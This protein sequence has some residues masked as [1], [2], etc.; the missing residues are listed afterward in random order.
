MSDVKKGRKL[1]LSKEME[2]HSSKMNSNN[3]YMK[4]YSNFYN[5]PKI[6]TAKHKTPSNFKRIKYSSF[7]SSLMDKR[8][9][10]SKKIFSSID[11]EKN[12]KDRLYLEVI[13]TKN[14]VKIINKELSELKSDYN[15]LEQGN[16]TNMHIIENLL[17]EDELKEEENNNNNDEE[18]NRINVLKKH[19]NFYSLRVY[20]NQIKLDGLKNKEKQKKYQELKNSLA[21]KDKQIKGINYKM[22][23]YNTILEENDVKINYY[24]TL[25]KHIN[26][27]INKLEKKLKL[28][29]EFVFEN[30][31][32]IKNFNLQKEN[33]INNKKILIK[34]VKKREKEMDNFNKEEDYYDKELEQNKD[35]I[36]EK[37]KNE[38]LLMT[39]K[40]QKAKIQRDINKKETKLMLLKR[41]NLSYRNDISLYEKEWPGI[42][43]RSRIPMENQEKMKEMEKEIERNRNE[44]I[45][46]DKEE[47]NE[48]KNMS[49]KLLE[50]ME[51]NIDYKK[52]IANFENEKNELIK[53]INNLKSQLEKNKNTNEKL[54]EDYYELE[55]STEQ[56]KDEYEIIL[57]EKAGEDIEKNF[58]EEEGKYRKE[59][60]ELEE[61][62]ELL[63][64]ETEE[65][66]KE[67]EDKNEELKNMNEINIKLKNTLEEI[68]NF[69]P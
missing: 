3:L 63:K 12:K 51:S 43:K 49:V 30:Q 62:N 2:I 66:K 32:E 57:K 14:N 68:E 26:G 23:R 48:E 15:T 50:K 34:N 61:K 47:G 17:N 29:N 27:D 20:K 39:L 53:E 4:T 40:I 6:R 58:K 7:R 25:L 11:N 8:N 54:I 45:K 31:E 21:Y 42:L 59:I 52:E 5:K 46:R 60:I 56:K 38:N 64:K 55:I 36:E 19:I 1:I 24:M 28:N 10:I 44:I 65:L 37:E 69:S 13:K 35:L 18:R 67:K 16:F 41:D 33:L 9:I 22:K